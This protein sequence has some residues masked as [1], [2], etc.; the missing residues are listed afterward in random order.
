MR[1]P[2]GYGCVRKMSGARRRPYAVILTTGYE[3]SGKQIRKYLSYHA[4]KKEALAALAEYHEAPFDLNKKDI[5]F[6]TVYDSWLKTRQNQTFYEP[7]FR[8]LEALHKLNFRDIR[9][10][11]IQALV[12]ACPL[13]FSTKAKMKNLCT[14]LFRYAIEN[15]L[16][17]TNFATLVELP[18]KQ[19]STLHKPFTDAEIAEL[20]ELTADFNAQ[21]ALILI[22][23]G[24]RPGELARLD[25]ST[26][27]LDARTMRG[28]IKTKAARDRI[29]PI[30]KKILPIVQQYDF[31]KRPKYSG[32]YAKWWRLSAI[33]ALMNH[34]PH[35]G[36][37]TCAT[38]LDNADVNLKVRKLILGHS[39][40]DITT[41]TYTHKTI[42][43]LLDAVDSI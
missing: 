39:D 40:G 15:E 13:G 24:M 36:R 2:N 11:H 17:T 20:W 14:M 26:I 21:T 18:V 27:D 29:I 30:A 35:D 12:D 32:E 19:E 8:R 16:V 43:Q 6:A 9:K 33:P 5:T 22:Y 42:Q 31:T 28:G 25:T 37:H 4:T 38:L 34:L 41:K 10:R 3:D 1:L 7:S 23:T